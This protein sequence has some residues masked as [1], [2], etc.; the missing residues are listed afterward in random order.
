MSV[1]Q[2]NTH[3][4]QKDRSKRKTPFK[5]LPTAFVTTGKSWNIR[6]TRGINDKKSSLPPH[7]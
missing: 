4:P 5:R 3:L 2:E 1:P 7:V 6:I